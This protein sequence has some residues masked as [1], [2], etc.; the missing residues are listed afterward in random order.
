MRDASIRTA[1]RGD[2]PRL[3]DALCRLSADLGDVHRADLAALEQA[4][5]GARASFRAAL[6]LRGDTTVGALVASP[7]FSTTLGGSGL[8]VSDLWVAPEERGQRLGQRLLAFAAGMQVAGGA[9]FIKLAVYRDNPEAERF[10]RR[11]GFVPGPS[12]TSLRLSG[13]ALE[14]LKGQT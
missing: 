11:L 10:Y 1:T 2:L 7:L 3:H 8:F 4:G 13:A 14:N 12:E 9:Q 6:A 5:F